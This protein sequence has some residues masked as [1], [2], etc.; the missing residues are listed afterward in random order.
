VFLASPANGLSSR[1]RSPRRLIKRSLLALAA[2]A[3]LLPSTSHAQATCTT[4][5]FPGGDIAAFVV[6]L[7]SG[8]VG[9]LH[10]GTFT[11]N[12]VQI[13]RPNVTLQS[14]PRERALL[15]ASIRV[16]PGGN[17]ATIADLDINSSNTSKAWSILV[18]GD[19]VTLYGLDVTNPK[20]GS[21]TTGICI[22]AGYGAESDPANIAYRLTVDH[23]RS[24]HC[25]DD[26]HEHGIYLEFTRDAHIVD[27]VFDHSA[28][29]GIQF[30]P[31][32]DGTLV[33]HSVISDN[34]S[35]GDKANVMFAG[36]RRRGE[37]KRSHT[38]DNNVIRN[39]LITFAL[40]RYDVSSY[41]PR[42]SGSP[43]GNV[44]EFSC[45]FGAPRGDFGDLLAADGSA[46]YSQHDNLHADP[47]Y[48]D[49]PSGDYRLQAGSPC[50]GYGVR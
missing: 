3:V 28:G 8:S 34:N 32:A 20:P 40:A 33:E 42:R 12:E 43:V 29:N 21:G 6:G 16:L 44:V 4:S 39:S 49:R 38:S 19:D 27:S 47:H 7:Q 10:A 5:L 22:T 31:D 45:L 24:H 26:A 9:C 30:Y 36:E 14:Y 37:Y 2:T 35:S 48:I 17:F 11:A 41:Y 18:Q 23:V 50:A 13:N 15:R 46:A 25:G 1:S